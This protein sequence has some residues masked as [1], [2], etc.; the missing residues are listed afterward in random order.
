MQG[1]LQSQPRAPE[2]LAIQ[3]DPVTNSINMASELVRN[4]EFQA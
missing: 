3:D 4:A 2:A 1:L